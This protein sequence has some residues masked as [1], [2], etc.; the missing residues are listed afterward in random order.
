MKRLK[1]AFTFLIVIIL[2]IMGVLLYKNTSMILNE[3]T[4][5]EALNPAAQISLESPHFIEMN[6][7]VT[8]FEVEAD[9]AYYYKES[10]LAHLKRPSAKLYGKNGK[11]TFI[12]GDEGIINT[13]TNNIEVTG[14][15][16]IDTVDGY[17]METSFVKYEN[18]K[19]LISTDADIRLTGK[20]FEIR[21]KGMTTRLDQEVSRIHQN[22]KAVFY[23][24]PVGE[25]VDNKN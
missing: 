23:P 22:V 11:N 13:E 19:M 5:H 21:G 25:H 1:L 18:D 2:V 7:E 20:G 14:N 6:G 17:Y 10:N 3:K 24:S 12:Q 16:E 9:E 8:V 15:V 4:F